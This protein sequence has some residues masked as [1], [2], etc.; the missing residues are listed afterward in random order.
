[1]IST[2]QV[3]GIVG[4]PGRRKP[5]VVGF[6]VCSEIAGQTPLKCLQG[7]EW[8]SGCRVGERTPPCAEPGRY[9]LSQLSHKHWPTTVFP[10]MP[11]ECHGRR[12]VEEAAEGA[13]GSGLAVEGPVSA[14]RF[15]VQ[16]GPRGCAETPLRHAL[17]SG[18]ACWRCSKEG[19]WRLLPCSRTGA[20]PS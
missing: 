14:Q 18:A 20:I 7:K 5:R 11:C 15:S 12:G 3:N 13:M 8:A 1:M 2:Q 6:L 19:T 4:A 10:L 16:A 17:L 9:R